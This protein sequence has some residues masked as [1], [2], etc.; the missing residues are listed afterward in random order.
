MEILFTD[1]IFQLSSEEG[2][3]ITTIQE[4]SKS[5]KG[6]MVLLNDQVERGTV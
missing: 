3:A 6:N 1:I 4:V 5:V 2:K